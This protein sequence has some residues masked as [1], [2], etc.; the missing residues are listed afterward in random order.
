MKEVLKRLLLKKRVLLPLISSII[1]TLLYA[2]GVIDEAT[3][4]LLLVTQ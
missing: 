1:A 3:L 2:F 4:K